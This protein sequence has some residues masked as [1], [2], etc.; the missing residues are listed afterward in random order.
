MGNDKSTGKQTETQQAVDDRKLELDDRWQLVQ[1]IV[2]SE[3]FQ[4]AAQLRNILT[5]TTRS[6]LLQ[7]SEPVREYDIAVA[8]L[9]RKP[10]FD[11]GSDN[12]VRV[13]ISHLRRRLTHYFDTDGAN[14]P[15]RVTMLKGSYI[16]TFFPRP[17]AEEAQPAHA[18][19]HGTE[20]E[21]APPF[22][23][24]A[25][26]SPW[27]LREVALAAA[28]VLL[29]AVVAGL[30]LH[31]R[32]ARNATAS[33]T[34]EVSTDNPF[35]SPLMANGQAVS[36]VL[37][38]TSLNVIQNL[39]HAEVD[40]PT[41]LD[42]FGRQLLERMHDAEEREALTALA[43]KRSTNFG[44]AAVA[45]LLYARLSKAGSRTEV[46]YARD[47]HVRDFNEQNSIIL[48]SPRSNP[49]A[50][51][52]T[53]GNTYQFQ[54]DTTTGEY[55]FF[56]TKPQPGQKTRFVPD[57]THKP[58][59]ESYVDLSVRPNL[60]HTG[61]VLL[62]NGSDMQATESAVRFVLAGSFPAA[63]RDALRQ[64]G[65][66]PFEVFMSSHHSDGDSNATLQLLDVRIL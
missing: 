23:E 48:G 64:A 66:R 30:L 57:I 26:R 21:A 42:G 40:V 53:E 17:S 62:V 59:M 43:S 11:P 29:S 31:Q 60:T 38:D 45:A 18:V 47:L 51:L 22:E 34:A 4:R 49:W 7:P 63:L 24:P 61:S 37:S 54:R 9:G 46:R 3:G 55:S 56:N 14:E 58:R 13:Q 35:L 44:E 39:L 32:S 33:A 5:Y 6:A 28:C 50:L 27:S 12:I 20:M 65:D 25:R 16:P 52:F 15:L 2:S 19:A 1:R 10:D 36:I 8:A 41:Y